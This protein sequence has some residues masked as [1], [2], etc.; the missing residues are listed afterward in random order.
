MV[1]GTDGRISERLPRTSWEVIAVV[2]VTFNCKINEDA[3]W[4]DPEKQ[5]NSEERIFDGLDF[6]KYGREG[7]RGYQRW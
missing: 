1:P 4:R 3:N 2:F 5:T 6:D 7:R